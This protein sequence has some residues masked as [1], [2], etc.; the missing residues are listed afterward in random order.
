MGNREEKK[1]KILKFIK[2]KCSQDGVPPTVREICAAVGLK[3]PSSVHNYLQSLYEEGL[4]KK[5]EGKKRSVTPVEK[6]SMIPLLG[7]VSA[8]IP[9]LAQQNFDGYM[10]T[11]MFTED[12]EFFALSIK[13]DSMKNAGILDGDYVVVKAASYAENGDIVVA[14]LDD[15]ATC[16][17][18]YRDKGHLILQPE[19][20]E[21]KRIAADNMTILGVVKS[22][23][24]YYK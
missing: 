6:S 7:A 14:L 23:I 5:S 3:S 8:G 4:I 21:Y 22:V 9:M 1:A 19:N 15:E 13:G 18:F 24:R 2:K 16:K 10:P 12:N 17:R 11:F 20:P